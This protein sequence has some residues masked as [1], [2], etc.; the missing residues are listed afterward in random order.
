MSETDALFTL[1]SILFVHTS[2]IT[3]PP[4]PQQM[5]TLYT[6][7]FCTDSLLNECR[8]TGDTLTRRRNAAIV[9]SRANRSGELCL[10]PISLM[11]RHF[12]I[13]R[14]LRDQW[15]FAIDFLTPSFG[16][17]PS[18]RRLHPFPPLFANLY[19]FTSLLLHLHSCHLDFCTLTFSSPASVAASISQTWHVCISEGSGEGWEK[20]RHFRIPSA[21]ISLN[22]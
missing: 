11:S 8:S 1:T 20:I 3:E 15:S 4:M 21:S 18:L 14:D 5:E 10:N 17:Q 7:E 12:Y 9:R 22:S 16:S 2:H 13:R 6:E 19:F